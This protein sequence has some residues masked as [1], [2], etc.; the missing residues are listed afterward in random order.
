M[1]H[2]P[3]SRESWKQLSYRERSDYITGGVVLTTAALI[4]TLAAAIPVNSNEQPT[5]D[6]DLPA[7]LIDQRIPV[8]Y[9]PGTF[10]SIEGAPIAFVSQCIGSVCTEYTVTLSRGQYFANEERIGETIILSESEG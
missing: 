8:Q 1:T 6:P 4:G 3:F 10:S 9:D 5:F 2:I 7:L